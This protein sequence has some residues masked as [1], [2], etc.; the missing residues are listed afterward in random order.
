[1]KGMSEMAEN[2][3]STSK[4]PADIK[5]AVER[6]MQEKRVRIEENPNAPAK[7]QPHGVILEKR[8]DLAEKVVQKVASGE[9]KPAAKKRG[10][11]KKRAKAPEAEVQHA[12]QLG[13]GKKRVT[14]YQ[15]GDPENT[16]SIQQAEALLDERVWPVVKQAVA[17]PGYTRVEIVDNET[18]LVR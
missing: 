13:K 10:P 5:A 4:I 1:M 6:Q 18:V 2:E 3:G 8:A 17:K 11:Y 7:L 9:V 16:L 15:K 14:F 12:H